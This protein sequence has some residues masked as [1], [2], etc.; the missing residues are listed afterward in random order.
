[1]NQEERKQKID[2]ILEK[3]KRHGRMSGKGIPIEL[4]MDAQDGKPGDPAF[5]EWLKCCTEAVDDH[6]AITGKKDRNSV[7]AE[8]VRKYGRREIRINLLKEKEVL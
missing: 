3:V 7:F 6:E 4:W 8:Y 1:M 2:S 5:E